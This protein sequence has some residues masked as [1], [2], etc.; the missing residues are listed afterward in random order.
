MNT[1]ITESL[2]MTTKKKPSNRKKEICKNK[3][4]TEK[5]KILT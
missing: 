2:N 1:Q 5:M 4:K 3:L